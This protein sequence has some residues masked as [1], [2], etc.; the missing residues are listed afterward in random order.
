MASGGSNS[1]TN[2]VTGF[3]SVGVLVWA[4]FRRPSLPGAL[5]AA[6]L[7]SFHQM[8]SDTS[9]LLLPLG[10]VMA[11][12]AGKTAL[13]RTW[14]ALAAVLA[15][16]GPSVLLFANTQFYLEVLPVLVL[17]VLWKDF[18]PS[19]KDGAQV[20]RRLQTDTS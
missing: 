20:D 12:I 11:Q 4:A 9:L 7:V 15:F 19:P 17:F 5:L 14:T 16:I 13:W 6:M 3:L 2:V 10:L 8:I 1:F 18:E